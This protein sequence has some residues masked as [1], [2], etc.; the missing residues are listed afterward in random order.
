MAGY[1]A[2]CPAGRAAAGSLAQGEAVPAPAHGYL[3]G[4]GICVCSAQLVLLLLRIVT[5]AFTPDAVSIML[6]QAP[7]AMLNLAAEVRTVC[8]LLQF[9]ICSSKVLTSKSYSSLWQACWCCWLP[10]SQS[11]KAVVRF[12]LN[13]SI[14]SASNREIDV[15]LKSVRCQCGCSL[16]RSTG[17]HDTNL[18]DCNAVQVKD[19]ELSVQLQCE[20]RPHQQQRIA[21]HC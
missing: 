18:K 2:A 21:C 13:V 20:L 19:F 9:I 11:C 4:E 14:A 10:L 5:S 8:L 3:Q 16:A 17:L 6:C 1:G 12:C 15:Q 7:H